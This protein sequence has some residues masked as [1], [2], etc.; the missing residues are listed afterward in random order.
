MGQ[1]VPHLGEEDL[2]FYK[3]VLHGTTKSAR[4]VIIYQYIRAIGS[5]TWKL[6]FSPTSGAN[7]PKSTA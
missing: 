6:G 5:I 7:G 4:E 3:A 1:D 2:V